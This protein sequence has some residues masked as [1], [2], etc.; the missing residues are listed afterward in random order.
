[1]RTVLEVRGLAVDDQTQARIE[2]CSNTAALRE[3]VAR[4]AT[5][6]SADVLFQ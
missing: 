5:I 3:L 4:A 2:A 6:T 1:L